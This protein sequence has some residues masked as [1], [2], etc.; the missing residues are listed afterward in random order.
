MSAPHALR[1]LAT[2]TTCATLL[3]ACDPKPPAAVPSTAA[4]AVTTNHAHAHAHA[5]EAAKIA[6]AEGAV[7]A[8]PE[9]VA[10]IGASSQGF[11][12]GLHRHI[13]AADGN[14]FASP[15][16]VS[17]ALGM[18]QAGAGGQTAMQLR[19]ALGFELEEARLH[20]ALGTLQRQLQPGEGAPYAL[21]IANRLWPAHDLKLRDPFVEVTSRDY[22]APAQQLD[23]HKADAARKTI[24]D[25][26]ASKTNQLIKD[27]IP[28][29]ILSGATRMVLTNAIHFK[30][31]WKTAFDPKLTAEAPFTVSAGK[32]VK[33]KLMHHASLPA[34][35]AKIDGGQ[36]LALPF[37][38]DRLELVVLLP[39]AKDGLKGFEQKLSPQGLAQTIG[40]L[41]PAKAD[42]KLPRFSFTH[43]VEL[44]AALKQMGVQR[45]FTGNAELGAIAAE[46]LKV[47]AI[48]HKAFIEVNEEGAEAAAATAVVM[49]R[50]AAGT[51]TP[52]FHADHA[53]IFLIRDVKTGAVLFMGRL[54]DPT[55]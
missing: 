25:W 38:G 37:K 44:S 52:T 35:H 11:A 7:D 23:F 36:A 32:Q 13:G 55:A 27:L 31:A 46:P 51:P 34:R 43:A 19:Q 42:V 2:L 50:G 53:F 4:Q 17:L 41:Q 29:G 33:A 24:N 20:P 10:Q 45:L 5:P 47:D 14:V 49:V 12:V 54:S 48:F 40:A 39:D 21:T 15:L 8:S 1:A 16:S 30:G 3:A 28:A 18:V 6:H 9:E 22:N 26:V